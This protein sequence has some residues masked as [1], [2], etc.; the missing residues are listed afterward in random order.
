M[1][2]NSL[3]TN[4]EIQLNKLNGVDEMP[5]TVAKKRIEAILYEELD[6][7]QTVALI[8]ILAEMQEQ[9][10][11]RERE[12][13][14]LDMHKQVDLATGYFEEDNITDEA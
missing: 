1:T 9:V 8:D 5:D 2:L 12:R 6:Y 3:A 7:R 14:R 4:L 11:Q 13:I 10:I